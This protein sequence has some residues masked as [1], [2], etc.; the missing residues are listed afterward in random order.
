MKPTVVVRLFEDAC[1]VTVT[2]FGVGVGV[3]LGVGS[4]D[5]ELLPPPPHATRLIARS[6]ATPPSNAANAGRR[7]P[8]GTRCRPRTKSANAHTIRTPGTCQGDPLRL[9]GARGTVDAG[10]DVTL[11]VRAVCKLPFEGRFP[12]AGLKLQA[13]PAARPGHENV[14][15]SVRPFWE[16]NAT[17]NVAEPPTGMVAAFDEIVPLAPWT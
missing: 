15:W 10:R 13:T 5:P 1:T 3:G 4:G 14:N 16:F 7:S 8:E 11:T 2:T 6:T 17:L 9:C 12:V